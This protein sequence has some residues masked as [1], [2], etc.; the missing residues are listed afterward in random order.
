MSVISTPITE[1]F[2]IK[3]PIFLAGMNVAAGSEL[4]AAVTNAG[5]LGVIGDLGYTPKILPIL[6]P[7]QIAKMLKAVKLRPGIVI[8]G[9]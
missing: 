3:H 6:T 7:W 4:A 8:W 1:W 5:G 2:G 9:S